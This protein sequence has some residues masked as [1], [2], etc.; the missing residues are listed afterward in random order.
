MKEIDFRVGD[1][2][3]SYRL[4]NGIVYKTFPS[5]NTEYCV[6]V[7]IGDNDGIYHYTI[8]GKL[9]P[10]DIHRSLFHGHNLEFNVNEKLPVRTVSKWIYLYIGRHGIT[11]SNPS[12]TEEMCEELIA[13]SEN[14][15]V[16]SRPIK[17]DMPE[18]LK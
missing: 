10:K 8:D 3:F 13:F 18:D 5:K 16:I 17:V 1:K 2:V 14:F 11:A 9:D 4:G 7:K 6:A 15:K 12:D